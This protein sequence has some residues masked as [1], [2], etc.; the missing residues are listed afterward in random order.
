MFESIKL[1]VC[2]QGQETAE[3]RM[4][5]ISDVS[6]WKGEGEMLPTNTKYEV[7]PQTHCDAVLSESFIRP[8]MVQ[9]CLSCSLLN[10]SYT[11]TR[12]I[13]IKFLSRAQSSGFLGFLPVLKSHPKFCSHGTIVNICTCFSLCFEMVTWTFCLL[14]KCNFTSVWVMNCSFCVKCLLIHLFITHQIS[15]FKFINYA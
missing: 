10:F 3:S 1:C 9:F 12:H 11:T 14:S 15:H 13:S 7:R 8:A 2:K 4:C 5:N 6:F